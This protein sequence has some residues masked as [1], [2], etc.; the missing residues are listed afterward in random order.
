MGDP[1]GEREVLA[2]C[3]SWDYVSH[4]TSFF[5]VANLKLGERS[6]MWNEL[7]PEKVLFAPQVR[8]PCLIINA[9]DDPLTVPT[10]LGLPSVSTLDR[11]TELVGISSRLCHGC[12]RDSL[13]SL[14]WQTIE[15]VLKSS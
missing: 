3:F 15:T 10:S 1:R 8:T 14:Q 7:M 4:E 11:L 2:T 13:N 5:L 9:M 6:D 12:S